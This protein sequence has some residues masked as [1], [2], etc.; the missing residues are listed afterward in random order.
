[1]KIILF[2]ALFLTTE[3]FAQGKDASYNA[4]GYLNYLL[5]RSNIPALGNLTDQLLQGRLNTKWYASDAFTFDCEIRARVYD[6]GTVEETPQF[7]DLIRNTNEYAH[8]DAIL[9][10]SKSSEGLAEIDRL[11]ADWNCEHWDITVGRQRFALGTNLVWNP[12]DLFNPYSILDFNYE[13]RPGFDGV[14][15]QYYLG[16][17]SKIEIAA[18]PGR[19]SSTAVTALVYTTNIYK[20]DFHILIA[21]RSELWLFGGSW[22]GDIC[23][24]GFRGEATVSQKP[25][26][27]VP[28]VYDFSKKDGTMSSAAI[29]AD[30]TF[31]S[32]LYI[33]VESLYNSA[34]VSQDAGSFTQQSQQLELLSPAHWSLFGEI[35]YNITPLVRGSIF[36]ILNPTDRSYVLVPSVTWSVLTNL[37][38][39]LLAIISQ[40]DAK[41]EYAGYGKSGYVRVQWS[42]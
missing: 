1:M 26:Q 19:T 3:S 6:G 22:A 7:I 24:A 32:S 12:T 18:K 17:L 23:G 42:F 5:S 27:A 40:G 29:S 31:A 36:S 39:M 9:W 2:L 11:W 35:S 4:G 33:H 10:N 15:A 25:I 21:N 37:D 20:Y 34:G 8:L 13:E 16:P 38:L 28:G 30:Y 41:T 14:R